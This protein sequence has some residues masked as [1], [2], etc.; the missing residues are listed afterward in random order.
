MDMIHPNM[1][2]ETP[3]NPMKVYIGVSALYDTDGGVTPLEIHWSDG[4][5]FEIDRITDVRHAAAFI[6]GGHGVRY[7][8]WIRGQERFLFFERNVFR[9]EESIGRWFIEKRPAEK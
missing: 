3:P 5:R 8:V 4:R 2:T 9:R 7:T 6:A 1:V